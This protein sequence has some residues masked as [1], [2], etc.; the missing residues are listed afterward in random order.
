MKLK[1]FQSTVLG[2][3]LCACGSPEKQPDQAADFKASPKPVAEQTVKT[4][5]IGAAAGVVPGHPARQDDR[6]GRGRPGAGLARP[7]GPRR[8]GKTSAWGMLLSMT[9]SSRSQSSG[10]DWMLCHSCSISI[11]FS[12]LRRRP[13]GPRVS[14]W[15][16]LYRVVIVSV[17]V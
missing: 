5:E 7:A 11:M 9:A 14:F 3:L 2:M 17:Q 10:A 16:V 15:I 4:L 13:C 6:H 12:P 8:Q 1:I